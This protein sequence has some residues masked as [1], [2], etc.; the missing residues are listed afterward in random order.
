MQNRKHKEWIWPPPDQWL[1]V[2][3]GFVVLI[4][5]VLTSQ[6]F[7]FFSRLTGT[8]WIWCYFTGLV[9]AALGVSL[10]FYAKLPLYRQ[11]R[12]FTFGSRA[13][14]EERRPFYRW[15]YRCVIIGAALLACLLLSSP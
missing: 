5:M 1:T 3:G 2:W 8:P 4:A 14:P 15:G 7:S 6:L 13:L 11:R 9:V 12:F 10:L